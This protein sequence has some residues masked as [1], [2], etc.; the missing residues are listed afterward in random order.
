MEI[1]YSNELGCW[2]DVFDLF[3]NFEFTYEIEWEE[4]VSMLS[5]ELLGTSGLLGDWQ[6]GGL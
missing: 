2:C 3:G 6:W 4:F 5:L 1:I